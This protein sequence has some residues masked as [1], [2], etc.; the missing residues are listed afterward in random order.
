MSERTPPVAAA[1]N[2]PS[3]TELE[4]PPVQVPRRGSLILKILRSIGFLFIVA[5]V[6]V[7]FLG[8]VLG[9]R[10]PGMTVNEEDVKIEVLPRRGVE[11]ANDQPHTLLVSDSVRTALGIR[12]KGKDQIEVVKV[13][14]ATRP[15]TL[16]GSTSLNPARLVRIRARFAPCEVVKIG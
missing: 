7:V 2:H 6:L 1:A 4:L 9:V 10:L 8:F 12:K 5:V 15:L 13:P 11:L 14:T 16:Y 3:T